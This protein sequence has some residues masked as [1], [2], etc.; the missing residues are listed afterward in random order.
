MKKIRA[1]IIG[2][3]YG[4]YVIYKA[5]LRTKN[6]QVIAVCSRNQRKLKNIFGQNKIDFFK[7]WKKMLSQR[8]IDL[9]AIATVPNIQSEILLSNDIKNSNIKYYFIE[10]PIAENLNNS[11]KIY[12]KFKTSKNFLVDFTFLA[13]D[14]FQKYKKILE[15]KKTKFDQI[16]IQW[17][18]LAYHNKYNILTW[19]TKSKLGGGIV[20]F[21]LIH[22]LNYLEFFFGDYKISRIMYKTKNSLGFVVYSKKYNKITID[23]D[24]NYKKKPVHKIDI[25]GKNSHLILQNKSYQYFKNFKI[26]NKKNKK[27]KIIH[28]YKN[29]LKKNENDHRIFPVYKYFVSLL[30]KQKINNLKKGLIA[31]KHAEQLLK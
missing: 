4:Y 31:S 30:G 13:T 23:F 7:S 12:N 28:Q 22:L 27:I 14:I 16:N 1:A 20:N 3:G 15:Q 18:F 8:N 6:V 5:L 2:S 9:L 21:Y 19:K 17:K 10:K 29:I 11:L 24:C 26:I 25:Y